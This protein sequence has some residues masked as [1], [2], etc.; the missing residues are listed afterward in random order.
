VLQ[1]RDRDDRSADD[2]GMREIGEDRD[3]RHSEHC[4]LP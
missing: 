4:A 2:V 1:C 3:T